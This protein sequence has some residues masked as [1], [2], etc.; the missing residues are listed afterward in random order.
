ME[1]ALKWS[2]VDEVIKI[3]NWAKCKKG[4]RNIF[5]GCYFWYRFYIINKLMTGWDS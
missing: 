5:M 4:E 3:R 1:D 2:R